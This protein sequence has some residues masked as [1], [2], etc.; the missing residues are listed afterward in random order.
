MAWGNILVCYF[1]FIVKVYEQNLFLI[2]IF[3]CLAFCFNLFFLSKVFW[4]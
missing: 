4:V 2:N 1:G 3:I